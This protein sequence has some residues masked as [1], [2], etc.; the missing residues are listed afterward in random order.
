MQWVILQPLN[1]KSPDRNK[2]EGYLVSEIRQGGKINHCMDLP[3]VEPKL[4]EFTESMTGTM[5]GSSYGKNTLTKQFEEGSY[6]FGTLL[7]KQSMWDPN[8]KPKKGSECKEPKADE[9]YF[10]QYIQAYTGWLFA[11]GKAKVKSSV[12]KA[13]FIQN[14]KKSDFLLGMLTKPL[15]C[16]F[17]WAFS[18]CL[19]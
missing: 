18:V 13:V 9:I 11:K 19:H 17:F 16:R 12:H 5:V 2:P 15:T 6:Y 7:Q 3:H 8:S 14:Y 10:I 4:P 1:L